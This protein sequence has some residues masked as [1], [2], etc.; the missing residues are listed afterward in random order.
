VWTVKLRKRTIKEK[1][2]LQ[3]QLVQSQNLKAIGTLAGGIAHDFNSLLMGIQIDLVVLDMIMHDTGGGRTYDPLKA[4][5][6]PEVQ[7]LLA[8]GYSIDG[9]ATERLQRGCNGFIQK[10]FD[11]LPL[12]KKVRSILDASTTGQ[13]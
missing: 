5:N 10:P 7:V 11:L 6:N 8:S 13:L 12:S 3:G 2:Q 1:E 9:Q 4:I